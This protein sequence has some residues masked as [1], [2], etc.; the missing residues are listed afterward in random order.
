MDQTQLEQFRDALLEEKATLEAELAVSG[1]KDPVTG[2]WGA[3]LE[4][5]SE[6][7]TPDPVDAADRDEAFAISSS[8]LGELEMRLQ[9][10]TNALDKIDRND[11]TYG[12]CEI[13]GDP[14]ELDRLVANPAARTSKAHMN[15]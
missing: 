13:S 2:D 14:I 15:D 10:I 9:D 5:V 3:S 7:D 6:N 4:A 1:M 11:G 12:I 8:T